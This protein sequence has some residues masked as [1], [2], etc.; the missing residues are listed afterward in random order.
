MTWVSNIILR[1]LSLLGETAT[2]EQLSIV[3]GLTEMQISNAATVLATH[4]LIRRPGKCVYEITDAGTTAIATDKE[5]KRGPKGPV[6]V[7][8]R[9]SSFRKQLW[10]VIRMEKKGTTGDF[11]SLI[12]ESGDNHKSAYSSAQQYI[13]ALCRAGYMTTLPVPRKQG[14]KRY[15]RYVLRIDSGPHPPIVRRVA[16]EMFDPNTGQTVPLAPAKRGAA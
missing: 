14:N 2:I 6:G 13:N 16:P 5:I 7:K 9:K 10:Q 12:C 15:Q 1:A 8:H 11:I 3:T 4:G